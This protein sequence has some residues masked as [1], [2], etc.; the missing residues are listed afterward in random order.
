MTRRIV[1]P[2]NRVEG[3]LEVQLDIVDRQVRAA[4]VNS[5]LYRGFEQILHGKDPRDALVY[6]PRICGI[7]SVAQSAAAAAALAAAQDLQPARNGAL[8]ANLVLACENLADHLSHFYLFFMPDF[9]REIYADQSWYDSV[10][11]RFRALRGNAAREVLRARAEFMHIMGILAGKW[12]HTLALQPGGSSRAADGRDRVRL[13]AILSGFRRFLETHTFGDTL[14]N[15]A[16]LDSVAA[17]NEWAAR[18]PWQTSDLRLFWH[19]AGKLELAQLGRAEDRFMSYGA[20]RLEDGYL[21]APGVWDGTWRALDAAQIREDLSHSWLSGP[22]EP[23]TPARGVTRPDADAAGA[24]SWCKAP[25]L[26]GAIVEV[27]ALA[28][29]LVAGHALIRDAVASSGGNV[30]NRV[31]ARLLELALLVPAMEHW[32]RQLR[33]GEAFC[34]QAPLPRE[35]QGYGLVEAARGSLGHWLSIRDGVID[36]YQIIAPTTWNFSPRDAGGRPGPLEQALVGAPLR[37]GEQ[38]PVAVQHIVRSFDPCMVC[39][40]H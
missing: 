22:A 37:P 4:W 1:G 29:Q 35:A 39:T 8:A 7:C 28:R 11:G 34:R 26:D 23:L 9:A 21:F 20:Y 30:R 13:A 16:A 5:P 40:V 12:P 27:G 32:V 38:T 24:Y 17:L 6:A 3:D 2:F 31:L 10:A 36:N 33:V 14:E 19:L 15:I 25:R 18:A